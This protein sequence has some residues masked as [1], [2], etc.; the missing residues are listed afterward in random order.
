MVRPKAHIH[1]GEAA[2]CNT[3]YDGDICISAPSGGGCAAMTSGEAA[4]LAFDLLRLVREA[5]SES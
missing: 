2:A 1:N 4:E 3:F 5:E